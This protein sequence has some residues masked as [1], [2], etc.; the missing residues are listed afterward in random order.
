MPWVFRLFTE[1]AGFGY[2]GHLPGKD[3]VTNGSGLQ[4]GPVAG[5]HNERL[6]LGDDLV[7]H[8]AEAAGEIAPGL[9]DGAVGALFGEAGVSVEVKVTAV[10]VGVLVLQLEEAFLA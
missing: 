5:A 8:D 1:T 6:A 10:A 3:A 4:G 2:V 9:E 7:L